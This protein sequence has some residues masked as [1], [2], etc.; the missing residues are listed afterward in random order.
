MPDDEL[1]TRAGRHSDEEF[2]H[3][4]RLGLMPDDD[5]IEAMVSES[6]QGRTEDGG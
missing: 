1:E 2:T 4:Q 6:E 3:L 5:E